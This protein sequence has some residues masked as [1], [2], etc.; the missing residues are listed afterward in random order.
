MEQD[1]AGGGIEDSD[2][3][4]SKGLLGIVEGDGTNVG[5]DNWL[6]DL[7]TCDTGGS[8][9]GRQPGNG[10]DQSLCFNLCTYFLF[11]FLYKKGKR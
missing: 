4:H 10:S 11:H 8:L 2:G 5:T 1:T 3:Y 6:R 7:S 9:S